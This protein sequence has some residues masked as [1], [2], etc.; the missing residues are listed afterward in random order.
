MKEVDKQEEIRSALFTEV[1]LLKQ[2]CRSEIETRKR[3]DEDISQAL[4]K[5]KEI[6]ESEVDQRKQMLKKS[7][8]SEIDK[9]PPKKVINSNRK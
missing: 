2:M 1:N 4:D 8:V 7:K 3:A 9:S 6:I 5:Y